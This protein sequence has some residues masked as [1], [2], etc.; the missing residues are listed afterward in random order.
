MDSGKKKKRR[1]VT[2]LMD[3]ESDAETIDG[4]GRDG[5]DQRKGW[6]K[7]YTKPNH[8]E[9]EKRRRDKMN[10]YINEL[11]TMIPMCNA[12]SRKLDK[13]TVLRMAVQHMKT[14]KGAL[15]PFTE[16][17]YKPAFLSD[18]DLKN[19]ILE[20]A[21]G[22]LFVV[23]CDR[24]CLLYASD[25]IQNYLNQAPSDLVGHSFLDLVHQKDV[26]KV[27]EQLS[28]SDT[29]PRERLIDAKTGLPLKTENQPTPTRLCSGARRSFFCRMK[30]GSKGKKGKDSLDPEPCLMKRK[31]KSKQAAQPD[32][33]PYVVV[34]CT[35]Y[36]KSW[37]PSGASLDDD[38][39]DNESRNLSCLV[40]VG[41]LE[42]IYDEA[43]DF[44]QPGIA[45]EFISR[46]SIDGKFIFVD[47]RTTAITGYLPQE[48]IGSSGYEY[49]HQEDLNSIAISH[50]RALQGEITSTDVYRFRCKAGH[51]LPLRTC[52]NV[53]RNPWSKELEF[54]V[55]VNTVIT[56]LESM[57]LPL[58]APPSD[59]SCTSLQLASSVGSG[60]SAQTENMAGK[61]SVQQVLEILKKRG[62]QVDSGSI[63][64]G[65]KSHELDVAMANV[66]NAGASRIGAIVAEQVQNQETQDREFQFG[67]PALNQP[68]EGLPSNTGGVSTINI[69][70][71]S[72]N[73]PNAPRVPSTER[74]GS[75]AGGAALDNQR[76]LSQAHLL[77]QLIGMQNAIESMEAPME[78][79]E[80]TMS[81]FMNMLEADAG[82]GGEFEN[83]S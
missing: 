42:T 72:L 81:V 18:E 48:L 62:Q 25:S 32:K 71:I 38:D 19:L 64:A 3:D 10:T 73:A 33:K 70:D 24:G 16:T 66:G 46:H 15:D 65:K 55:C 14:L 77:E 83:L 4:D 59:V 6:Q 41:R 49:F 61:T 57:A 13:L 5:D 28:S 29:T 21:D 1:A 47:Q 82:L 37:P 23:G 63:S 30:C 26:N 43:T 11:S 27:K 54:L 75:H 79:S 9:I 36:L 68:N 53:F 20:A 35:G 50:R 51:Y 8:S 31:S 67:I 76:Q 7:T 34:H 40:A 69:D 12:M 80:E 56:G 39:E 60:S 2:D 44:S 17:N 45:K 58:A 52:S 78:Q 22:F 74:T